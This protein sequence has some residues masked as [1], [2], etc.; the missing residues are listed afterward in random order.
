MSEGYE[1]Y[2][3]YL[4]G[5]D[6]DIDGGNPFEMEIKDRATFARMVVK[7]KVARSKDALPSGQEL[8][9]RSYDRDE[10]M[11]EPWAIEIVEELD[12]DHIVPR[13]DEAE[14]G[15]ETYKVY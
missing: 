4:Q 5:H 7:A 1:I 9:I 3:V 8:W 14:L 6:K 15:K 10:V 12:D 2:E 13:P 11:E